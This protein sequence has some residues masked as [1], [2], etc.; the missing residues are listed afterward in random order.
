MKSPD[1][2]R[3]LLGGYATGSLTEDEQRVLFEAALKDQQLFD[4][5]MEEQALKEAIES[6]GARERLLAALRTT[7]PPRAWW[8]SWTWAAGAAALAAVTIAVLVR[9]P[10]SQRPAGEVAVLQKQAPRVP[11][12]SAPAEPA[13]A[14][15]VTA[16]RAAPPQP[17]L[18]AALPHPEAQFRPPQHLTQ[19][20]PAPPRKANL[21]ILKDQRRPAPAADA[22]IEPPAAAPSPAAPPAA[23]G[24]QPS[25]T[26]ADNGLRATAPPP[27]FAAAP[28][29][30]P[31]SAVRA[32]ESFGRSLGALAKTASAR[33]ILAVTVLRNDAPVPPDTV[34][35]VGET[36][37]LS[38]NPPFDGYLYI[39]R[40]ETA[41]GDWTRAFS[42]RARAGVPE[43]AAVEMST[44][45]APQ[46][47]VVLSQQPLRDAAASN[48]TV[49]LERTISLTIRPKQ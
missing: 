38:V 14:R 24:N 8:P 31:A 21:E 27:Q 35:F 11:P 37:R 19:P 29:P 20:Q 16:P 9:A 17:A 28:P 48:A 25:L 33:P 22:V 36:V 34:F 47:R 18:S 41:T 42:A 6:P 2:I 1:D 44:A 30:P 46:L 39:Q 15:V 4:E 26:L 32:Q 23:P 3:K 12:A 5:L 43:S 10:E 7:N 45:G 13:P 49:A 40:R